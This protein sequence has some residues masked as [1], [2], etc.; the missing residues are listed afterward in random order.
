[1]ITIRDTTGY[2]GQTNT[3]IVS[4]TQDIAY[5]DG[6]GARSNIYTINQPYGFLTITPK[7][8]N[9][10]GVINTFAFPDASAS[11]NLNFLNVSS[12]NISTIGY[13]QQALI[14]TASIS[15]L[16]TNNVYIRDNLSVGQST[17]A[18]AGFYVCSIRSLH[19]IIASSNIYA[20]S[21]ISSLMAN[22]T[23]TLTVPYISTTNV[24]I[25][26]GL[27]TTSS[28]STSGPMF[29]GSSISTT[30]N[31]AVGASTFI[32]GQLTVLQAA[33]FGSSISTTGALNV[34]HE[35]ILHSTLQVSHNSRVGASLSVMSSLYI[36]WD[37][38]TTSSI[39][40][41]SSFSTLHDV[42]I[43]R[44]LSTL[45]KAF[46][47]QELYTTSSI[48]TTGSFS[49]LEDV[50]VSRNVSV[51][52][53]LYV[54]GTV[55]FDNKAMSF[56]DIVAS[57]I[58]TQFNI[59][60]MSSLI[61]G[62]GLYVS[63]STILFGTVSTM[64]NFN[65]AGLLST[66]STIVAGD[67][68]IVA[69]SGYFGSNISTP[70]SIGV[71]GILRV[72]GGAVLESTLSTFGEA[73]FFSSVQIQ[74]S[75][76][77]MSS[78][79]AACN[80]FVG[81]TLSTSNLTLY[82]STSI[83]T[84]AVTNTVNF[85]LNISSSTLHHGLFSTSGAMNI[86][87]LISTTNALTVGSTINT[88]FLDVRQTMSVFSNAG[89]AQDISA[90]SSLFVGMS[91]LVAGGFWAS[92]SATMADTRYT[93]AV[94][95]DTNLTV[96]NGSSRT[97][98]N[99]Q[100]GV[101]NTATFSNSIFITT[102]ISETQNRISNDTSMKS[103]AFPLDTNVYGRIFSDTYGSM[104]ITANYSFS[105]FPTM[106]PDYSGNTGTN[107]SCSI[108]LRPNGGIDF[109]SAS[110]PQ[111][112]TT[113]YLSNIFEMQPSGNAVVSG[114]LFAKGIN[115][116][117][118]NSTALIN[119]SGGHSN[120][121]TGGSNLIAFGRFFGAGFRHYITS[122]HTNSVGANTNA[123]DFW[124]NNATFSDSS[125]TA[126]TGNINM[127]SVTAAGLG[128]NCN[129]PG[130]TLDV[131]GDINYSGN[132]RKNGVI[133]SGSPA[134]INSA[135]NIGINGALN[136][137][138]ALNVNGNLNFT[139]T[140]NSNGSPLNLTTA[141]IN[142]SGNIGINGALNA[143]YVL[144]V[145]GDTKLDGATYLKG[146]VTFKT[147]LW[148]LSDDASQRFHFEP[149]NATHFASGNG[150][151]NFQNIGG[152]TFTFII[153][154]N[155]NVTASGNVTAYSDVRAKENIVTIDSALDKVMSLRGVYYTRK[156]NPGPRHLGVI[157]QEV[158]AILPEVVMTDSEGKKSVAYGN[159]VA[160]LLEAIKEQQSTINALLL[161]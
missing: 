58:L 88:Q 63:Q 38:Y 97:K 1:M 60:S 72:G 150:R 31:L 142:S 46:I 4:T 135:G 6:G 66:A 17:I 87:G 147:N 55:Q 10:W 83:S 112:T 20:G 159:I 106:V 134:G 33:F 125:S 2:A 130:Y 148:Q 152:T 69:K 107:A 85:G 81:N 12:M 70:S 19:D 132:L 27:Q 68:L 139:G 22:F 47:G 82:G 64:S 137:S 52:G 154:D 131:N 144:N 161:R 26:G 138:F 100:L 75:L 124:L 39:L 15:T 28:I 119:L 24:W 62:G 35:T 96:G 37:V 140:I 18:H 43:G 54:K 74:G 158:E 59:S 109:L 143:N 71:G 86:G 3:I 89:F 90:R 105:P 94:V 48:L 129:V 149:N 118:V 116:E 57:S 104:H 56:Q 76:S 25:N 11:A 113:A 146:Q 126:G 98:I 41:H 123:I 102:G 79:V 13:I 49:T 53:N 128:I 5:L 133:F 21:T 30:G 29:V 111:G 101:L 61:A 145:N 73:A 160:L 50:N 157:A 14:S 23:S 92:K 122:R 120:D 40:T 9:L 155:G 99:G 34:G 95:M 77:V 127:M 153:E 108:V 151:F 110:Y 44:N 156:D 42:N 117:T 103:V 84:L 93:G 45:G 16:C 141:G 91:T 51:L 32:Q 78:I 8:S 67:S 65:I 115:I 136:A 80:L 7:T 121:G 36:Q 114:R